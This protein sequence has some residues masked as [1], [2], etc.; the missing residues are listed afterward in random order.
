MRSAV[1]ICTTFVLLASIARSTMASD[2]I[3]DLQEAAI[4]SNKAEFGHWGSDPGNYKAWGS[5]SNRLIPVYTFGTLNAGDKIDLRSYQGENS[6]YR[7]EAELKRIYGRLPLDTLNPQAEF[8]DQTNV[9]DI[10]NAA[11]AAGKKY[12]F[13]VVFDGM[14]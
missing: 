1:L 5:H 9:F 3:R 11:L 14:D 2:Y 6:P 7:S 13:L 12:I 8:F 10:Q 4:K